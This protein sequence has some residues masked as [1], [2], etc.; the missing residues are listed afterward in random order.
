MSVWVII[1]SIMN[2]MEFY[3]KIEK[4]RQSDLRYSSDAYE[5]VNDAVL[6][7]VEKYER[8]GATK[9]ISAR[10]LLDGI[11]DFAL[12]EFGPMAYEVFTE[13]GIIDSA[14]V[15]NIVFNMIEQGIL[16]SSENDSID[17]FQNAVD[18]KTELRT[19]FL[20]NH[21]I[22]SKVPTIT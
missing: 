18:F 6:F 16:S 14:A 8:R 15:G 19:P 7:A 12:M 4:I 13:W 11:R 20:P 22:S 3:T 1:T 10:E 9:H 5:F 2:T 17:E 21:K